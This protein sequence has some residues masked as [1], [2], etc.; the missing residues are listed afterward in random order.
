ML[1][2]KKRQQLQ[3][4][5]LSM[6][7]SAETVLP[8]MERTWLLVPMSRARKLL[9]SAVNLFRS[10]FSLRREDLVF[11]VCRRISSLERVL[12]MEITKPLISIFPFFR[13]LLEPRFQGRRVLLPLFL[14]GQIKPS[15]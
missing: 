6:E 2:N 4:L 11:M 5:D 3:L 7:S 9:T 13:N 12:S 1:K 14:T 15:C 8:V 10:N